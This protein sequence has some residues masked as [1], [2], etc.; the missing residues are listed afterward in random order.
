MF[1]IGKSMTEGLVSLQWH[2]AEESDR[3]LIKLA[4]MMGVQAHPVVLGPC[5]GEIDFHLR[6]CVPEHGSRLMVSART[7]AELA[8]QP[9]GSPAIENLLRAAGSVFVYGFEPLPAH[10]ALLRSLTCNSLVSVRRLNS[11]EHQYS[12][13]GTARDVC[14]QLTGLAFGPTDPDNDSTFGAGADPTN[15]R[16]LIQIEGRPFFVQSIRSNCNLSLLAGRR[17]ADIDRPLERGVSA[18]RWFSQLVPAMMF[19]RWALTTRCWQNET[20]R[21]CFIVDDPLLK[22]NYGFLDYRDLLASMERQRFTTSIAFI[23]W[24]HRK[25]SE[26]N[27]RF[28]RSNSDRYSIC[29][30]G[31]DHTKAEFGI[32]DSVELERKVSLAIDRME[33]HEKRTGLPFDKVMVFPQGI[34]SSA[35]LKAL[36]SHRYVA[37]VNSTS[38]P[39]DRPSNDLC[40]RDFLDIAV[41]RYGDFPLFARHYPVDLNACAFDLF[42][43]RPLLLVEH[44]QYFKNGCG[45]LESFVQKIQSIAPGIVWDN[46]ESACVNS[47]LQKLDDNGVV[48]VKVYTDR[49]S[50][51]NRDPDRREYRVWKQEHDHTAIL[52]VAKNGKP[53]E[54]RPERGGISITLHLDPGESAD[55]RWN[56]REPAPVLKRTVPRLAGSSKVFI[57]R[58]L[59]RIRDEYVSKIGFLSKLVESGRNCLSKPHG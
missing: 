51:A 49:V 8:G 33:R 11:T 43:G 28:F 35:A 58:H 26:R 25:T 9:G 45:A 13:S 5:V 38:Y 39:V 6:G 21:A 34:F 23:P 3:N 48:H 56:Y 4:E 24:N 42:L 36:K 31:C 57:R 32:T 46:L 29:V 2:S 27:A 53:V 40:L 50:I 10:E 22:R 18:L 1:S 12:V 30:H 54:F 59:C 15:L 16:E 41:M 17:I 14:R 19:L 37:A 7:L 47:Y 44:H 52:G 55:L 20:S